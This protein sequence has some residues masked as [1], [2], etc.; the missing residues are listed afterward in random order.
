MAYGDPYRTTAKFNS[1][2]PTCNKPI[3][4]GSPIIYYPKERK[5]YHEAC[6][7]ADYQR[8]R[9]AVADETYLTNCL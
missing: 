2:C 7:Q 1:V 8:F 3:T 5:A 4:K 9:E 6:G